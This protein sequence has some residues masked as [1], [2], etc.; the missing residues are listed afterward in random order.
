M[1]RRLL[2]LLGFCLAGIALAAV[3]AE[4]ARPPQ[5]A[6]PKLSAKE[7]PRRDQ[8]RVYVI[9]VRDQIGSAVLYVVRRGLK[10]AIEKGA[11]AVVLDMKTPGGALNTTLEIMEAL[12]R[13]PGTSITYV[14]DQAL[15]AGAFISATTDEIW[16][17]PRGKIGAAAPVSGDGKDIDETMRLKVVS[18]LR[19][20]VRSVSEGRGNRGAAISAMI[21]KDYELKIGDKVIKPKGELLTLTAAE[22]MALYGEPPQALLGAG[23]EKSVDDLIAKK[24]PGA[25]ATVTTLELTWSEKLASWINAVSPFLLGIGL[26]ALFIEFKTPGFGIFGIV[27]IVCL[28]ILFLGNYVAGLSGHEPILFFLLGLVL[29]AVEIFFFPGAVI[30]AVSGLALMLGSLVWSMADLWP[31][32]PL[33]VAWSGDAFA[34]PLANVGIGLLIA[35]GLGIGLARFLPRGWVWDKLVVQSIVGGSAQVAGGGEELALE[36]AELKGREGV[37]VTAL[38]PSGQIEIDGRRFEARVAVGA[39]ERGRPV[40]VL[41]DSDFGLIVEE[42]T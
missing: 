42:K 22:A 26:L 40:I 19:A 24:Y 6:D 36:I 18:F 20:E 11:D 1:R 12:Q 37:A 14:N 8:V 32:E 30:M 34:R 13:F 31:N 4:P 16:F 28:A 39:I 23:I 5:P 33:S 27:G 25:R 2:H 15:S 3:P 7:S 9:P 17:A 10:E 41:G 29:L 35:V 21:D 38:R